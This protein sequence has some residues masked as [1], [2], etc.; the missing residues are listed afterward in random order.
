MRELKCRVFVDDAMAEKKRT[1]GPGRPIHERIAEGFDKLLLAIVIDGQV[2]SDVNGKLVR[3]HP[4]AAML[5][6]VR[7][8]CKDLKNQQPYTNPAQALLDEAHRRGLS[9]GNSVAGKIGPRG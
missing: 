4:S 9:V 6:V 3:A 7:Q 1:R 8:R 5:G 2:T